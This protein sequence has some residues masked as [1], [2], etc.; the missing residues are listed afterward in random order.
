MDVTNFFT[1][2]RNRPLHV[3][4]ADKV[5]GNLR[6]HR[7]KGGETL[8]GLDEKEY[9]FAEGMVVISDDEGIESIGGI[10]GGLPT[11]CTEDTVNVFLE[12]AVWDNVQIAYT[13]RG[14]KIN[15]D[16]RY[17]NERGI[18]PAFNMEAI[19]LATQMIIGPCVAVSRR[20]LWLRVR[21]RT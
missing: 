4:D 8:M 12:A 19:D 14:L 13:G 5:N 7:A 10:M 18:D 21:C 15:S 16:A 20:R 1:F 6:V 2:D 9:T 17:R 3:F 11:G